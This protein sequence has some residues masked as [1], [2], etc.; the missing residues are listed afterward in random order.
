MLTL[1]GD[2]STFSGAITVAAG[3][4]TGSFTN[5]GP[6]S[7]VAPGTLAPG[8]SSAIGTVVIN[9]GLTIGGNLAVKLNKSLVQSNDLVSVPGGVNNTNNGVINV[10]NLGP[11]LVVGDKFTLFDQPVS[12]GELRAL[13][14]HFRHQQNHH[15]Q[16]PALGRHRRFSN[17]ATA[18]PIAECAHLHP[19]GRQRH[20]TRAGLAFGVG[21]CH[22][23]GQL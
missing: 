10:K 17:C 18:G 5:A 21:D 13:C 19:S 16:H 22:P 23:S 9:G 12:G 7:I 15:L 20:D 8:S 6:A 4:L 3:T 1:A 2:L 14:R 11:A